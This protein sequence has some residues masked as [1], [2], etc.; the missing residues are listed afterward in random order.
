M[1]SMERLTN[2]AKII[3]VQIYIKQKFVFAYEYFGLDFDCGAHGLNVSIFRLVK[4]FWL[5]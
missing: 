1:K 2:P 5:M 4:I 3:I